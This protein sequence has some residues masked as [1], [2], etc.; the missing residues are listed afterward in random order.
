MSEYFMLSVYAGLVI[1]GLIGIIVLAI[2]AIYAG[3]FIL[4]ALYL[5]GEKVM[6]FASESRTRYL[7]W[8]D[9]KKKN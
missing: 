4:F 9:S 2:A 5:A 8:R 6:T 7:D 3:M 1:V